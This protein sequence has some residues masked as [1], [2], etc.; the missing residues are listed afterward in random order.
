MVC[1]ALLV[2]GR[3]SVV[4]GPVGV[5]G[6]DPHAVKKKVMRKSRRSNLRES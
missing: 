6:P 2:S 3:V 5:V 1:H 4:G